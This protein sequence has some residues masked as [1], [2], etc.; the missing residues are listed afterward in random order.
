MRLPN[1]LIFQRISLFLYLSAGILLLVYAVGFVSNVYIFYAY[2]NR[3]LVDFYHDMQ[4]IND[5]LLWKSILAIIFSLVLFLLRLGKCPAGIIT[6]LITVAI[7]AVSVWFCASSVISLLEAR[8][9]YLNLNF[10]SLN[11]YIERGAI[12]FHRSTLT[13]DLGLGG[14][15]LF[16]FA[17]LFMLIIV[18]CNAFRVKQTALEGKDKK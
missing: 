6:L 2:G 18:L 9:V 13:Y 15:L 3:E 1:W 8:D 5:D 17:S 12:N 14:Y 7:A 4:V 10:N 16:L 11:R